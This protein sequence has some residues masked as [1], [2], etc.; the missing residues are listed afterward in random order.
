MYIC[1]CYPQQQQQK[2]QM[3][4]MEDLEAFTNVLRSRF[5][6]VKLRVVFF[7]IFFSQDIVKDYL[8]GK[9]K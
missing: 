1:A 6:N 3:E 7:V 5:Y 9:V 4:E 2:Q 8:K